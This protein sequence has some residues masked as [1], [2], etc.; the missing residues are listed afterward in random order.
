MDSVIPAGFYCRSPSGW[1][2]TP[3]PIVA[4][5]PPPP[6]S[7]YI[8][9]FRIPLLDKMEAIRKSRS[10]FHR[11]NH[12]QYCTRDLIFSSLLKSDSFAIDRP[13]LINVLEK[14]LPPGTKFACKG[15]VE[16]WLGIIDVGCVATVERLPIFR[17]PS[18]RMEQTEYFFLQQNLFKI[19]AHL[20][21]DSCTEV[22]DE[23][24][25]DL[26]NLLEDLRQTNKVSR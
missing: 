2:V 1:C 3:P 24:R 4:L 18:N 11:F 20:L 5:P 26:V 10:R 6:D 12:C 21:E 23:I 14:A 22:L 7:N 19:F 8:L 25:P 16:Q 13:Q 9:A 17:F 15:H